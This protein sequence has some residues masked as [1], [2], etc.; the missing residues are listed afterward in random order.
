METKVFACFLK[1]KEELEKSSSG[2]LFTALSNSIFGNGG[3]VIACKYECDKH[4]IEFCKASNEV[5]R[6]SMRGS[7]YIKADVTSL[8][9]VLKQVVNEDTKLIMIVGTPCQIVGIKKWCEANGIS[10]ERLIF[11]DLIC[12]GVTSD[13]TWQEYV[14]L[15]ETRYSERI[16]NITFKDKEKG[17]LRPTA[18]AKLESGKEILIED[19]AMLYRSNSFMRE[20]CYN[21]PFASVERHSD[22]TIGDYWNYNS[23]KKEFVNMNGTSVAIINTEKGMRLF[24][25]SKEYL[26]YCESSIND[27]IQPNLVGPTKKGKQYRRLQ[28]DYSKKGLEYIIDKYVYFGPGGKLTRKIRGKLFRSI[29]KQ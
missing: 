22:I 25:N 17:W 6:D 24:D 9:T 10:D 21:C 2:G 3:V 23:L 5:E 14:R 16:V 15:I 8:Y 29:Y 1:D 19:Y 12:H 13:K 11:V 28:K 27:C 26:D 20:A 18:K 7:K 4:I